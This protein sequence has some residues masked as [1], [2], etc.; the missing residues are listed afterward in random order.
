MVFHTVPIYALL[1]RRDATDLQKLRGEEIQMAFLPRC[2]RARTSGATL[3]GRSSA[4]RA[5]FGGRQE[6]EQRRQSQEPEPPTE[7]HRRVVNVV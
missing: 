2:L 5:G 6:Q 1:L 3:P 7:C 4:K